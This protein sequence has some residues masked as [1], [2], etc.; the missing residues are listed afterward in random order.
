MSGIAPGVLSGWI[1]EL[2]ARPHWGALFASDPLAVGNPATV[3]IAGTLYA[4]QDASGLLTRSGPTSILVNS[5]VTWL[6]IEPGTSVVAVGFFD[7]AFGSTLLHRVM[8][9]EPADFPSGGG[10]ILP[11]NEYATGIDI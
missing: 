8:L 5:A 4:R 2:Y 9:P 6:N 7:S 11:A 10:W 1:D 3:E